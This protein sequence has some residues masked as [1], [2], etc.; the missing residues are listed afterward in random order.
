MEQCCGER[1]LSQEKTEDRVFGVVL[2]PRDVHETGARTIEFRRWVA[3]R[4][5]RC[6]LT[7]TYCIV[8]IDREL[9][10]T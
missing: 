2:D 8:K 1:R 7:A 10:G 9:G 6:P 5:V 4:D 3:G